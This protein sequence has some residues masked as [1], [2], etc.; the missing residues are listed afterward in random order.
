MVPVHVNRREFGGEEDA[1]RLAVDWQ[2]NRLL[3]ADATA[4]TATTRGGGGGGAREQTGVTDVY[5]QKNQSIKNSDRSASSDDTA[6]SDDDTSAGSRIDA[7]H[8]GYGKESRGGGSGSSDGWGTFVAFASHGKARAARQ[9]LEE[10]FS[11]SSVATLSHTRR[12]GACFLVHANA[13]A[14]DAL[15]LD[16]EEEWANGE[17][18][19]LFRGGIESED[20]WRSQVTGPTSVAVGDEQKR[21]EEGGRWL[22]EGFM[23]LP[24]NLKIAPTMLDHLGLIETSREPMVQTRTPTTKGGVGR[25][26]GGG[27]EG[28]VLGNDT[29]RTKTEE[30]EAK[31]TSQGGLSGQDSDLLT[32]SP[33]RAV[34][35]D[36]L[37][38]FLSPGSVAPGEERAVAERWRRGW[39]SPT[40]DLYSLSFWSDPQHGAPAATAT[41]APAKSPAMP[42]RGANTSPLRQETREGEAGAAKPVQD[43]DETAA[44]AAA[45]SAVH[46]REWVGA[47]RVVH[48]LSDSAGVTPAVACGWDRVRVSTEGPGFMTVRGD[49]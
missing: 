6:A 34:H 22:L 17:N 36:G 32:T 9:F 14:V 41:G 8:G 42:P 27:E 7:V 26:R 23:A 1:F 21:G 3:A 18:A 38:V 48:S 40:L 30:K 15:F 20:R 5:A 39:G 13:A 44:A 49:H 19:A 45:A 29:P 2:H 47:A 31:K 10:T 4:A 11:D 46:V 24:P 25:E 37:I 35:K 16:D 28:Y 12:H 33:G 43:D